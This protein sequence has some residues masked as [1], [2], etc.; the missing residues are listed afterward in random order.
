MLF[1]S[2]SPAAI[3]QR[4]VQTEKKQR[5]QWNPGSSHAYALHGSFNTHDRRCL[6]GRLSGEG[7]LQ[8]HRQEKFTERKHGD[9]YPYGWPWACRETTRR[10]H[11]MLS[12][13]RCS[14]AFCIRCSILRR[15]WFA[16]GGGNFPQ[17][18][19]MGTAEV[20]QQATAITKAS[21]GAEYSKRINF[22]ND[23]SAPH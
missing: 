22:P 23:I 13:D 20:L 6:T 7:V 10:R 5:K 19:T 8:I 12:T 1:Q 9:R 2:H 17:T 3:D 15:V 14:L 11:T 4:S 18:S 16:R 21:T